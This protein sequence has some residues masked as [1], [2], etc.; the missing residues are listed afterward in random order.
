M[1]RFSPT[2]WAKLLFLRD[3]G[4]TEIGGFG[5]SGADDLLHVAD[6]Q[7]VRQTCTSVSVLFDDEAVADFFDQQVDTGLALQRFSRLWIH[8][9]PGACPQ[10]SLTDEKTFS[11]VFGKM[12][13]AVMFILAQGGATYAR[14]SFNAGPRA[15]IEVPVEVDFSKDFPASNFSAWR[16]DY[17][18]CVTRRQATTLPAAFADH[19]TSASKEQWASSLDDYYGVEDEPIEFS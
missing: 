14:L 5:I 8:T 1:L 6:W 10:P 19:L 18:A 4:P 9:H 11:R 13:W 7:L 15:S 12:D 16:H 3:L 2:A 17:E